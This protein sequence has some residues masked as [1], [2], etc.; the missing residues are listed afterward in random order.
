MIRN[1]KWTDYCDD[2][3]YSIGQIHKRKTFTICLT[4]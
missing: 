2:Y 4:D 1:F 3:A